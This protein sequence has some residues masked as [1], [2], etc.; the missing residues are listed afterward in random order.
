MVN[1]PPVESEDPT[2]RF[3]SVY[4]EENR[5]F[6]I[7][8]VYLGLFTLFFTFSGRTAL[9]LKAREFPTSPRGSIARKWNKNG[10]SRIPLGADPR[11]YGGRVPGR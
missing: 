5:C 4:K 8:I 11:I 7:P 9:S 6:L 1:G 2:D 3:E 10:Y